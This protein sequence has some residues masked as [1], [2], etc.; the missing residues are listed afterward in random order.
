MYTYARACDFVILPTP[1][2]T[3]RNRQQI[4]GPQ[5]AGENSLTQCYPTF[6]H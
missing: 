4:P 3:F 5:K 6:P 1:I 2:P